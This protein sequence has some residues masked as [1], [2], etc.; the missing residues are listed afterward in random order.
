MTTGLRKGE[1]EDVFSYPISDSKSKNKLFILSL[2]T[3]ASFFIPLAPWFILYGYMLQI[4]R[5]LVQTGRLE[6]PEWTNWGR[7]LVDGA[8]A[9]GIVLL[10][11]LPLILLILVG[12]VVVF[13]PGFLL[14]GGE[15]LEI[16]DSSPWAVILAGIVT[17]GG[18]VGFSLMMII[19]IGLNFILPAAVTHFAVQGQ[20]K[21]AFRM[22]EVLAIVRRNFYDY[23]IAYVILV[24]I[25]IFSALIVQI[26]SL[27]I[28]LCVLIP[29]IQ[30]AISAYTLLLYAGLFAKAYRGGL[31]KYQ[32]EKQTEMGEEA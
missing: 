26:L 19:A 31:E 29:F 12:F 13:I 15:S 17:L 21:A 6:L 5:D 28:V 27:T 2:I 16:V 25:S 24:V 1:L 23:L 32:S 9:T 3:L 22:H 8:K 4:E 10:Y 30:S 14:A 11:N 7:F 18:F 20:F